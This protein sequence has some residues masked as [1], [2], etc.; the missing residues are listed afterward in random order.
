MPHT[1]ST[2]LKED[3]VHPVIITTVTTVIHYCLAL[4]DYMGKCCKK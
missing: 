1:A 3:V 4:H 2:C